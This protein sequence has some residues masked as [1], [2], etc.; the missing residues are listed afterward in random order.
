MWFC[1]IL[2]CALSYNNLFLGQK[3]VRFSVS[4]S[5]HL[6]SK[7]ITWIVEPRF[8]AKSNLEKHLNA[9]WPFSC[10]RNFP[11]FFTLI[12]F[13]DFP[14]SLC[15]LEL[16]YPKIRLKVHILELCTSFGLPGVIS[17]NTGL[18]GIQKN[19]T[20]PPGNIYP[21]SCS[22]GCDCDLYNNIEYTKSF[23]AGFMKSKG[24]FLFEDSSEKFRVQVYTH[25]WSFIYTS[26][27]CR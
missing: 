1:E 15:K 18:G 12:A 7:L 8:P 5:N 9:Y 6:Q 3:E 20:F 13:R 24:A 26:N 19:N 16:L 21:G 27:I 4:H 11:L 23:T 25:S 14:A 2:Y 17:W 10:W 22:V